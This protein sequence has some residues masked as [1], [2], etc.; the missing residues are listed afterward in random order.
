MTDAGLVAWTTDPAVLAI[1][2][3]WGLGEAVV[4]PIVPDVLLGLMALATPAALG[5]PLAVAIVGAV[6]G[7]VMLAELR[8]RRPEVVARIIAWQPGLGPHGMAQARARIEHQGAVRGFAQVGPGLPLK[9]YVVAF[10][11]LD[12]QP[13]W[14]RLG[15]LALV[16]RITRLVPVV[17][18]F[19]VVGGLARAAGLSAPAAIPI[20]VVGWTIFYLAFWWVRRG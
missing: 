18:G 17:A 2:L 10:L 20:Y 13:G 7:A 12:G 11:D 1:L 5:L 16:N 3:L 15:G 14:P 9:A 6:I 8:R 19:A 4:L